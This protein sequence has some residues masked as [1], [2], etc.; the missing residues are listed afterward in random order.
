M[1]QQRKVSYLSNN[2]RVN[3]PVPFVRLSGKWL[4]EIGFEIGSNFKLT[5]NNT[6]DHSNPH[7]LTLTPIDSSINNKSDIL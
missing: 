7:T 3:R 5:I 2:G 1:K 4:K 6:S